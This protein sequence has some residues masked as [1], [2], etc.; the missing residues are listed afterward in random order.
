MLWPYRSVKKC[1]KTVSA[2]VRL[3]PPF[4]GEPVQRL[5]HG[6][7]APDATRQ[8]RPP[9]P[10]RSYFV[11]RISGSWWACT[12]ESTDIAEP[13]TGSPPVSPSTSRTFRPLTGMEGS[14]RLR[15]G[16]PRIRQSSWASA[17]HRRKMPD[18]Q[19]EIRNRNQHT[20]PKSGGSHVTEAASARRRGCRDRSR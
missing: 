9:G 7:V 19:H 1:M 18:T 10:Y 16:R 6:S 8:T 4:T 2:H 12:T 17:L 5:L 3:G 15:N 11:L 20:P 14:Q 13:A